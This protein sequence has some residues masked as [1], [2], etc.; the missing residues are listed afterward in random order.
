MKHT[1]H[2]HLKE[3]IAHLIT[4]SVPDKFWT[5]PTSMKVIYS[6]FKITGIVKVYNI[7]YKFSPLPK[8]TS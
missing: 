5:S 3:A 6:S 2:F 7:K 8:L 4:F 1:F